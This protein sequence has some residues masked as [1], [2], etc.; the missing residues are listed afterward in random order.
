THAFSDAALEAD[1]RIFGVEEL[2]ERFAKL[3]VCREQR[4]AVERFTSRRRG[5]IASDDLVER[6]L[7]GSV[8]QLLGRAGRASIGRRR[9]GGRGIRFGHDGSLRE[10]EG[11]RRALYFW[12]ALSDLLES[13]ADQPSR[14]GRAS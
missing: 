13:T 11:G 2:L 1:Q 7:G 5:E 9:S 4:V 10:N 8:G 6:I 3:R 12:H 14:G